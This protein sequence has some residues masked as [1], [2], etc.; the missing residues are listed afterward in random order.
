MSAEELTRPKIEETFTDA[1]LQQMYDE[2]M[3]SPILYMHIQFLDKYIDEI[4]QTQTERERKLFEAINKR[5]SHI[6]TLGKGYGINQRRI[7]ELKWVLKTLEECKPTTENH[8]GNG[9]G[10]GEVA[11]HKS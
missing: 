6:E 7:G 8:G 10:L 1:S 3:K 4:E 11:E 5:I 2:Y 9:I